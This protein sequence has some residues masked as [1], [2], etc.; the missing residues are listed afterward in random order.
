VTSSRELM[1][2]KKA[3][4]VIIILCHLYILLVS[5][6]AEEA[7]EISPTEMSYDH[8][9]EEINTIS[10]SLEA[11]DVQEQTV[12]QQRKHIISQRLELLERQQALYEQQKILQTPLSDIVTFDS[13]LLPMSYIE[14]TDAIR[15]FQKNALPVD[16]WNK[17]HEVTLYFD[18]PSTHEKRKK[19]FG[20]DTPFTAALPYPDFKIPI[21]HEICKQTKLG[22]GKHAWETDWCWP[23]NNRYELIVGPGCTLLVYADENQHP[24][25]I[26]NDLEDFGHTVY[27]H[28]NQF[29]DNENFTVQLVPTQLDSS[30]TLVPFIPIDN[31]RTT[32]RAMGYVLD[33]KTYNIEEITPPPEERKHPQ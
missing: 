29:K 9:L 19:E 23:E 8:I 5:G 20:W 4:T 1:H 15:A 16:R 10:L 17:R 11:L 6:L 26:E 21:N 25:F 30:G 13:T 32:L 12:N 28:L 7:I 31:P 22:N 27:I 2:M 3:N 33:E 18:D 14:K 24:S